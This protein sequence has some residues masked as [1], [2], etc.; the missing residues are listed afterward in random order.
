MDGNASSS[1]RLSSISRPTSRGCVSNL[2]SRSILASTS[3]ERR[4]LSR[5]LRRSSPL[6]VIAG[7]S[8]PICPPRPA[9]AASSFSTFARLTGP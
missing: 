1:T 2:A 3:S 9:W 7:I 6:M 5:Y 4:T 8:L